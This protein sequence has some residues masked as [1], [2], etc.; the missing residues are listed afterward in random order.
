MRFIA[1]GGHP[2]DIL[3]D[4]VEEERDACVCRELS[5]CAEDGPRAAS[6]CSFISHV[7][8]LSGGGAFDLMSLDEKAQSTEENVDNENGIEERQGDQHCL[9][10]VHVR[11]YRDSSTKTL[12]LGV[13]LEGLCLIM[14][15][16]FLDS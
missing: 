16:G 1:L 5:E 3:R 10:C 2:R 6:E 7:T 14:G 9:L 8:T 4:S 12:A 15:R 11:S 13:G